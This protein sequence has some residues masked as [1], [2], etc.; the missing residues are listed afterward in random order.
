MPKGGL[1]PPFSLPPIFRVIPINRQIFKPRG[2]YIE[3]TERTAR[4]HFVNFSTVS[5]APLLPFPFQRTTPSSLKLSR[6][7]FSATG[8]T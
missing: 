6:G 3:S 7:L 8:G 1:E 5:V 2:L 4:A